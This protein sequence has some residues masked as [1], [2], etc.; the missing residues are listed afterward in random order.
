MLMIIRSAT[1]CAWAVRTDV[2]DAIADEVARFASEESTATDFRLPPVHAD[3]Y[4]SLIGGS[5]ELGP[6][7]TFLERIPQPTGIQVIDDE[8]PLL[9]HFRGWVPGEIAEGRAPVMAIVED[10]HPVSAC[11]CARRT[12]EAAEAGLETAEA[13]RGRGYGPRVTA[14][15]ALTVRASGRIPVYSTSWDNAASLAV[16][17]KMGLVPHASY[18]SL[19]DSARHK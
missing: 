2:A 19:T 8:Q 11:F 18:W 15:W 4:Q 9:H 14:A 10:G 13:Y 1:E 16:A 5:V 3:K 7:F 17:R 12:D 6:G